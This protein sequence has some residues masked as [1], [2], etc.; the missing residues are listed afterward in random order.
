MSSKSRSAITSAALALV[1]TLIS[2]YIVSQFLRNSVGVIAPNLAHDLAL[3]PAE[4][5][6][7]SSVFFFTFA[8]VQIPLGMALD[9]F[10]PR[11][12]LLVG[13]AIAVIGSIVF[14]C[15]PN[16]GVL[17]VGRGLQGLGT[18]GALVAPLA[19]YARRF[20]PERFATLSGLQIGLGTL[21]TLIATA[22]LAFSTAT[23]GWRSSFL[24]VA[25]FTLL[26]GLLVAAVVRDDGPAATGRRETLRQSLS[27]IFEV[28]RTPSVGRLFVMNLVL[29]SPFALIVGLWGGPYLAHI[30]G[31]GL[32]E[33]GSFLLI[34][35]MTQIAGLMLWGPMDRV[36]GSH[37]LPV[38]IGA[39]TTAVA[40]GY[41]AAVGTLS[42]SALVLWFAAFGFLSAF[43]PVLIAHGKSLMPT[44]QLGRGLTILNM[45]TMGGTF[46]VQAVSGFVIDL[47]PTTATGA[48]DL[49]AYRWV[50]G[51]QAGFILLA[52]LVYCGS[53]DPLLDRRCKSR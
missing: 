44:H 6:L 20:A 40:L 39:G 30:Y 13:A 26:I 48:Y 25:A 8:A 42:T 15:A 23:I 24:A 43:G 51:L 11:L 3:S 37:K 49:A 7:L 28:M 32:E 19:V 52:S 41:L 34:P 33:R 12:C 1:A 2:I 27:G 47:F 14:A 5:G 4:I 21:G 16:A 17:I 36:L 10:G 18:A 38:L 45:G 50:F 31:Y 35:V 29:Y 46:L 22:P 9:R 53:R